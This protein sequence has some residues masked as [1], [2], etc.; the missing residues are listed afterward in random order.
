MML[1]GRI[2]KL[3]VKHLIWCGRYF[4]QLHHDTQCT[5]DFV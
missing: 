4:T 3:G 5:F 2:T 1:G